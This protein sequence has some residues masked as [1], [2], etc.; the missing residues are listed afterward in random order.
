MHPLKALRFV[1]VEVALETRTPLGLPRF[2]GSTLRGWLLEMLQQEPCRDPA[3]RGTA[4]HA[5][6]CPRCLMEPVTR[7]PWKPRSLYVLKPPLTPRTSFTA[8][9][10]LTLEVVFLGPPAVETLHRVLQRWRAAAEA[11]PLGPR[12]GRVRVAAIRLR[13]PRETA[14][15][16]PA[17]PP[18]AWPDDWV[19]SGETF[20][21]RARAWLQRHP[22][23]A[24]AFTLV[25]FTPLALT[26]RNR[27]LRRFRPGVFFRRLAERL[28]GLSGALQGL[29]GEQLKAH[30]TRL[31]FP[32]EVP[33]RTL[34][35]AVRSVRFAMQSTRQGR[36]L[37]FVGVQGWVHWQ[38]PRAFWEAWLPLLFLGE[39]VHVGRYATRGMGWYQM[40]DA[41]EN[42]SEGGR[43]ENDRPHPPA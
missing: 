8:G 13:T 16:W 5:L 40:Q 43:S 42:A 27:V 23:V 24:P 1:R 25:L 10:G 3:S 33:F 9:E 39:H 21:P 34:A 2:K 41:L 17:D 29:S 12:R 35:R 31:P 4:A 32:P 11:H 36:A 38:A 19:W 15:A 18:A 20:W 6:L 28:L 30:L 22:E 7:A 37:P 26:H 14:P